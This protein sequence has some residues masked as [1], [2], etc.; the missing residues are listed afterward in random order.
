[1]VLTFILTEN[2]NLIWGVQRD[3]TIETERSARER[4]TYFVMTMRCD[5]AVE[6]PK[7]AGLL[8][9]VKVK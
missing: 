8:K 7:A 2:S 4:A 9:N 3:I 5:F 1:M 6:N